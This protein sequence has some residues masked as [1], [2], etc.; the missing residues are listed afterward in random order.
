MVCR[1]VAIGAAILA[2]AVTAHA[3]ERAVDRGSLV[4]EAL[5]AHP[6]IRAAE[7]RASATR[8]AGEAEGSLPPPEAMM[9]IWQVPLSK[10]QA[11]G[12]AQMIMFGVGQTFPAVGARAA[13]E[14]ASE[15]DADAERAMATEA[16][17]QIR[18]DIEHAFADYV[19]A[20]ARHRVHAEHRSLGARTLDL[21][22]A[23]HAGGGSLSDVSQA[24][25]ELARIDADLAT[26]G[27]RIESAARRIN[28]L[29]GRDPLAPLGPPVIGA[30]ETSAWDASSALA[31]ARTTRPELRAKA[32]RRDADR[33]R[34]Q[35]L[36]R[37][38]TIPSFSVAALYFVPTSPM[39]QHGYGVNASMTLPWLW[40]QAG[41]RRDASR[42]S[43][44][45]SAM[46]VEGSQRPID[47]E[48]VSQEANVRAATLRLQTLRDR[49]LPAS[50]RSFDVAWAG[51]EAART[52]LLTLLSTRRAALD[53]EMEV[54]ASRAALDHALAD[55]DAAVGAPVPR[56]P[57]DG[58]PHDR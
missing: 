4:A 39:P 27:T 45:A 34:T 55:L 52:D 13:R 41:A 43:G 44:S 2:V 47:G 23:R 8:R 1:S 32:A 5:R 29:A 46:D 35:A 24:D 11:L 36:Q 7:Q 31:K 6:A 40:G 20:T 15:H 22:R 19:E 9:Q 25:V 26:D 57:I 37:E 21:A 50:K 30:P 56:R 54:V 3:E 10:P 49:A 51:Y 16:A 42:E 14:R 18:R 12:D 33:E 53:I 38:A 28:A 17:R 48:V 58:G